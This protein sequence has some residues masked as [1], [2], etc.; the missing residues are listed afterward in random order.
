[1]LSKYDSEQTSA[2]EMKKD[3]ALA[4]LLMFSSAN[5]CPPTH[6]VSYESDL[7]KPASRSR[8]TLLN[9]STIVDIVGDKFGFANLPCK[10]SDKGIA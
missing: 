6:F 4:L 9:L 8:R 5:I 10:N 2:R 7:E 3:N 1:M